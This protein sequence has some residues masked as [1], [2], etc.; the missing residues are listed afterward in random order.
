MRKEGLSRNARVLGLLGAA[1]LLGAVSAAPAMASPGAVLMFGITRGGKLLSRVTD[2]AS[3]R[4]ERMGEGLVGERLL[5]KDRACRTGECLEKL[6]TRF[7]A[8]R[9]IGGEVGPPDPDGAVSI[10]LWLYQTKGKAPRELNENC[11][12]CNDKRLQEKVA[13]MT[14]KL[15]EPPKAAPADDAA[16]A[17]AGESKGADT[18]RPPTA[19]PLLGEATGT[20]N[21]G[22]G[23]APAST[24]GRPAGLLLECSPALARRCAG[25]TPVSRELRCSGCSCVTLRTI[26]PCNRATW[27]EGWTPTEP[28]KCVD[29]GYPVAHWV[30]V[31]LL[32]AGILAA[33]GMGAIGTATPHLRGTCISPDPAQPNTP[34]NFSPLL[35]TVGYSSAAV[36]AAGLLFTVTFDKPARIRL[37]PGGIR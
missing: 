13:E 29:E 36:L 7:R 14:G 22:S 30:R 10:T 6:A 16:V 25:C 33:A 5:P 37:V 12:N 26:D 18:A 31:G 21:P 20:H 19:P 23:A 35:Q 28:V 4:L 9:I 17:A 24:E 15:L 8:T 27:P 11:D 1:A 32:T 34:C 2:A 3:T